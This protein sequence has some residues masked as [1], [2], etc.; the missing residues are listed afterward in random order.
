MA[1]SK[2][3]FKVPALP[4]AA[5]KVTEDGIG[6]A[7]LSLAERTRMS[8][9][10]RSTSDEEVRGVLPEPHSINPML[11]P[12][13]EETVPQRDNDTATLQS[14]RRKTLAER[15][16]E[17]ISLAPAPPSSMPSKPTHSRTR[18]SLYP[19]NQFETP[20]KVRR[21]STMIAREG[22]S[23]GVQGGSGVER[24]RRDI[25]PRE[26]LFSPEA[27][28]DSV[29]RPRPKIRGSP[30]VSMSPVGSPRLGGGGSDEREAGVVG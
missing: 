5:K 26:Q 21:S 27:E 23:P 10:C 15:T 12:M 25:T 22:K 9:A 2:S 11:P 6:T 30:T 18:S 13:P 4:S 19:V 29:F 14:D 17:S 28:Y 20:M 1:S 24:R 16:R 8:M 3:G 7:R